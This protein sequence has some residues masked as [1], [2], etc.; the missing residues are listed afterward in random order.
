MSGTVRTAGRALAAGL[1]LAASTSCAG[2]EPLMDVLGGGIGLGRQVTGEIRS[3]DSR[4][5]ELRVDT[6][7]R[8]SE[9]IRYD[10]R[11]IVQGRSGRYSVGSLERGDVV[12]V[13]IEEGRGREMYARRI[14]LLESANNGRGRGGVVRV[15]RLEGSVSRIDH[16]R[17]TLDL[18]RNR[19]GTVQVV[20]PANPSR[21]LED[22]FQRIRKGQNIR[23]EG[24][25][26]N[27]ARMELVRI[28]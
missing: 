17:G 5:Q 27:G 21:S 20:L 10:G 14:D 16:R 26:I 23:V 15:E 8:G 1:V 4:R 9:R 19:A 2:Y 18:R 13:H 12:R 24:Y 22:R 25:F 6:D 28:F 3:I 11:T 7:W